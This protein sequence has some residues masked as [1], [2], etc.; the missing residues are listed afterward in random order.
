MSS[1]GDDKE[2]I[3]DVLAEY[4]FRIDD[5]RFAEFAALFTED[6]TWETAFGSATGRPAIE[7]LLR[8]IAGEAPRPRR[9]HAVS[10]IVIRLEGDRA[11]VRSNWVLVQNSDAG[12]IVG[13]GGSYTDEMVKQGGAWLFRHRKIDRYVRGDE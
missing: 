8:R 9:I 7:A 6:G 3:R 5:D 12:P 1:G 11:A 4:C 13:S 10:N 2:A